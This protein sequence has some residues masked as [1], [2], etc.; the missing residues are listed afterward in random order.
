[1]NCPKCGKELDWLKC[2]SDQS[3]NREG[4]EYEWFLHYADLEYNPNVGEYRLCSYGSVFP[5]Y[6]DPD[7]RF[8]HC[9]I[10]NA[11][12][13]TDYDEAVSILEGKMTPKIA[14]RFAELAFER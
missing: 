10:C 14:M 8:F 9:R 6:V 4:Y 13:T 1:M 11:L 5:G 2:I 12:L 3:N 7:K